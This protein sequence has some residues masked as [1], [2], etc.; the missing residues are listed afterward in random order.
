LAHLKPVL[1]S[2]LAWQARADSSLP[3]GREKKI[4]F[5]KLTLTTFYN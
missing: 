5:C 3:S 4:D 2:P 1:H